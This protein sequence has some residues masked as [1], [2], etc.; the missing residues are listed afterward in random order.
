MLAERG[1]TFSAG[2]MGVVGQHNHG[3]SHIFNIKQIDNN[4]IPIEAELLIYLLAQQQSD[5]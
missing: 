3:L 4:E 2:V 5:K 1:E